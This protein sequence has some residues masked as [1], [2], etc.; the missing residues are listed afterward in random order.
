MHTR[1]RTLVGL[2]VAT[3]GG[4]ALTAGAFSSSITATADLRVVV[5]SELT[6]TPEREDGAYVEVDQAGEVTGIVL[7]N[8][9]QAGVSRLNQA[10]V[11][12]FEELVR[13]TNNSDITVDE[14]GFEFEV[15]DTEGN[16]VDAVEEALSVTHNDMDIHEDG[17]VATILGDE[18]EA[19]ARGDHEIFGIAVDLSTPSDLPETDFDV[20]LRIT[21]KRKENA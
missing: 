19:L 15:T 12:R 13:I 14:L 11:S 17:G 1:R 4:G 21:A 18:S 6:L 2:L 10:A 5:T 20:Q 8:H 3:F 9:N 16:R 7:E